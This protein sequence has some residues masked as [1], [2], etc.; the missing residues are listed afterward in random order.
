[1]TVSL[2]RLKIHR[3]IIFERALAGEATVGERILNHG[4]N[5]GTYLQPYYARF[6]LSPQL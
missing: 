5:L 2:M 6:D 3:F 4:G 1:M